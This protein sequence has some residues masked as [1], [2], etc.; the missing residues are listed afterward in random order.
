MNTALSSAPEQVVPARPKLLPATSWARWSLALLIAFTFAKGLVW[1]VTIPSFWAADEDYHFLYVESLTTQQQL[2]DRDRPLFPAE[3]NAAVT[4]TDYDAYGQGPRK[5]FVGDPKRSVRELGQLPDS[6]RDPVE[7]GR[8]VG[9]VHPPLY[10]VTAAAVNAS[11]G[12]A[13][14]LTRVTVVRFLSALLG[15]LAVYLT[16]LLAA[17]VLRRFLHQFLAALLLAMQ[18]IFSY[19]TGVVNHDAALVACFTAALAMM[20]FLVRTPPRPVQGLWLGG[21]VALALLIK[22]TALVLLPLALLAYATQGLVYR[23]HWRQAA[24]SAGLAAVGVLVLAGWWYVHAKL[25]YGSF[26]G[27]ATSLSDSSQSPLAEGDRGILAT[28]IG[29]LVHYAREWTALT[30][31]TYWWN[32]LWFDAPRTNSPWFYV[33]MA[34]GAL[35][36]LG[37][38]RIVWWKRRALL[39][40]DDPLLRQVGLML[41]A[42][43]AIVLPFLGVDLVRKADGLGFFVNGGRYL[44]PAFGAVAVL[45][46]VGIRGLVGE[47]LWTPALLLA[48]AVATVFNLRVYE[49]HYLNRYFGYGDAGDLLRRLSFDRPEFVTPATIVAVICLSAAFLIAS[50]LLALRTERTP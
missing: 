26:T 17:Q 45:F 6:A 29:D 40:P 11:M 50:G 35:G 49:T 41:A 8:G 16:W 43:I 18:P 38:L 2:P 23:E 9:I 30:Y 25:A 42:A 1:A 14:I 34:T 32:F 3:Y 7:V 5:R 15:A 24:R 37:L 20:L 36:M 31:R 39:D 48:A 28:S 46:I 27:A 4:A 12:D 19:M 10:H 13:S 22:A 47:R 44:I 21:A 33:P